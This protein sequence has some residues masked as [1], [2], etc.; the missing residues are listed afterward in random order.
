[1]NKIK[2]MTD[3]A[4]DIDLKMA[5]EHDIYVLG[6]SIVMDGKSYIEGVDFSTEEFYEMMSSSS[7]FPKTSQVRKEQF[8][9]CYKKFFDEGYTDVIYVSISSTGS[10]T[11]N[12]SISARDD[13][14][15]EFPDA[16]DKMKIHIIDSLNYTAAYGYPLIAAS[17]KVKKGCTAEEII[18]YIEEWLACTE[19]H[20]VSYTLEYVKRSGRLSAGA[21]FM[22]E[23]LGLKPVITIIDGNSK[24]S[25]KIRGEKNI[26]PKM[27][28]L[29]IKNMTPKTPYVL[30]EGSLPDEFAGFRKEMIKTIGYPPKYTIKIGSTIASHAGHKVIGM[31]IKGQKRR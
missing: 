18:A 11:Y 19:L 14:Y 17:N 8:Y 31:V 13:F 10:A 30:L 16:A 12:N 2:I 23:L 5:K 15:K 24:V 1:M 28:E 26:I 3:S 4:S 25:E 29:A 27:T 21:A 9:E 6:F 20:F 22:G 7:D